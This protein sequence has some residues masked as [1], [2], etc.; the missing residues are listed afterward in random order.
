MAGRKRRAV[1]KTVA[2]VTGKIVLIAEPLLRPMRGC[3]GGASSS[4]YTAEA[5][6]RPQYGHLPSLSGS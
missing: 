6:S 3:A 1:R 4:G 5:A 2:F